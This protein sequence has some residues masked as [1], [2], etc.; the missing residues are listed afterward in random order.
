[1]PIY[2]YY[3]SVILVW[4]TTPL[5]IK[6]S[7]QSISPEMALL[8]RVTIAVVVAMAASCLF[9]VGRLKRKNLSVYLAGSIS[10]F[11]N[12]GLVYLS[13]N[14]IPSGL[15]SVLFALTPLTSFLLSLIFYEKIM[16]TKRQVIAF[17]LAI[18]GLVLIFYDQVSFSGDAIYGVGLMLL[19]SVVF[20]FSQVKVKAIKE[21]QNLDVGAFEQ[22]IAV[23]LFALPGL[24]LHWLVFDG[25][26]PESITRDSISAVLYL[27]VVGSLLGFAAYY[28]ILM[29]LPI[30]VVSSITLLTP[31]FALWLGAVLLDEVVTPSLLA[32]SVLIL[33]AISL[34]E[35]VW[36]ILGSLL[37]KLR[38]KG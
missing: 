33:L 35:G 14:F 37:H 19:S 21:A 38:I 25:A 10:V 23:M 30:L 31:M 8:S 3:L 24:F 1:M 7:S 16:V 20:S 28:K 6:L 9:G 17:M 29:A 32:G 11:P 15:I 13:A 18:S 26:V 12:M 5:A 2:I 4:S 34:F 27:A 22:A 36:K